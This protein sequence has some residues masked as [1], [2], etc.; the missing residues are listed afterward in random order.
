MIGLNSKQI[1]REMMGGE[2]VLCLNALP[3]DPHDGLQDLFDRSQL[4]IVVGV[5]RPVEHLEE[6]LLNLVFVHWFSLVTLQRTVVA[7]PL[8][9]AEVPF[10][11]GQ[12]GRATV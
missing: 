11:S 2:S 9:W 7:C 6:A 10:F 12:R 1:P 4:N 5:G 8:N 3:I